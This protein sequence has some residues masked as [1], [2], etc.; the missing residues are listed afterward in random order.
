M[1]IFTCSNT[2]YYYT[3]RTVDTLGNESSHTTQSDTNN[4][5]LQYKL[6]SSGTWSDIPSTNPSTFPNPDTTSPYFVHW[7]VTS[8]A[9][10]DYHLRAVA[11]SNANGEKNEKVSKNAKSNNQMADST[12]VTTVS[13]P[14]GALSSDTNINI[15]DISRYCVLKNH[16]PPSFYSNV[17]F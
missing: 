5:R 6:A 11:T 8:L 7:D 10:G 3:F 1:E 16:F 17:L 13:L 9:N 12:G 2:T 15:T 14:E 4:I